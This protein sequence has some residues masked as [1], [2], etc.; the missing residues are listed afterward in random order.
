MSCLRSTL[1]I[2]GLVLLSTSASCTPDEA[3][4]RREAGTSDAPVTTIEAKIGPYELDPG[5]E[6]THCLVFRMSNEEGGF[7]R[8]FHA[9]LNNGSHHMTFYRATDTEERTTPFE[10]VGFDS[11]FKGDRPLFIAQQHETDLAFP[12][13]EQGTPLGYRIDAHQ[14]MRMEM[15]YINTTSERAPFEAKVAFDMVPLSAKI[16]DTDI[17]FWG[18]TGFKI[19]P[20]SS[21]E[22]PV[23]FVPAIPD[24]RSFALTTHQHHFATRMR[25]W[26]AN[27]AEDTAS[28]PVADCTDWSNPPIERF[29]PPLVFSDGGR[30]GGK[31]GLAYKCEWNN[32]TPHEISFGESVNDEMCL[33]WHYYYPGRGFMRIVQP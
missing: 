14:M 25:V 20:N 3:A 5:A 23:K 32:P 29:D 27:S 7:I 1:C 10:C 24:S 22:T 2:S 19:P 30:D 26:H 33:L 18:T 28:E 17:A 13:D 8:R 4:S 16:V 12:S 21:Y 15:H 9:E 6:K 11:V 31:T